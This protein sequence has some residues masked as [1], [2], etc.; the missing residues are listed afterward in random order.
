MTGAAIERDHAH[1]EARRIVI[2][3]LGS[4]GDVHPFAGLGWALRER[5]HRVEVLT[6]P[7]FEN[8]IA[9][10]GLGF[11]P[12]GTVE[13]F[14]EA[15]QD[16]RLWHPTEGFRLV[17]R[18]LMIEHMRR[19]YEL[20]ARRFE[21]G[22]TVVLAPF[23]AFGARLA[24]EKLGVPLVSVHLQPGVI[25][26]VYD[27][28]EFPLPRLLTAWKPLGGIVHRGA[29]AALDN[30]LI[31]PA[32]GPGLNSF[33][34]ELGLAAVKGVLASW[35]HSPELV[36]GLFP[37]WFGCPQPDWPANL[38]LTGFPLFDE[39][40]TSAAP[41]GLAEFLAAGD[42]PIVFTAGSAMRQAPEFFRMAAEACATLGRRGVLITK[43]A[44]QLP[45]ALPAGVRHFAYIPFSQVLPSA[46]AFVHHGGIGTTGQ[47]LAAGVPQFVTPFN[48]D[49]PDNAERV[50]RIGAGRT[51]WAKGLTARKMVGH[52]RSLLASKEI[53][54]RCRELAG[55]I[56]GPRAI[57][58][59]CDLVE[60]FAARRLGSSAAA[61]VH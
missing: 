10:L 41:A 14:V 57:Q 45:A 44:E 61:K 5:G 52:L 24:Q 11:T 38:K 20:V 29:F 19:V 39:S 7:Y 13:Q 31:E 30:M 60:N 54:S 1:P 2:V 58:E 42:A 36:I 55:R 27:A 17:A 28:P 21:P 47:A 23:S 43:Y 37:D 46:A 32:L 49:Q 56:D 26:S 35:V 48:H 51:A 6:N 50:R 9:D 59:T 34:A 18:W 3:A 25:R 8:L 15:T 12:I 16:P 40:Q 53:A 4:A 33:R 22:K